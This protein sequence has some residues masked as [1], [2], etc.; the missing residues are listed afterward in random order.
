[1]LW[2]SKYNGISQKSS[3]ELKKDRIMHLI[4]AQKY[5]N[6]GENKGAGG[7]NWTETQKVNKQEIRVLISKSTFK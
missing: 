1:M 3:G 2:D 6:I 7:N 4:W 5:N